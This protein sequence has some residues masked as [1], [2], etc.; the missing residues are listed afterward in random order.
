[1]VE[2]EPRREQ[3]AMGSVQGGWLH[4]EQAISVLDL[5]SFYLLAVAMEM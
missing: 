1:M 5:L 4:W 3:A 2:V